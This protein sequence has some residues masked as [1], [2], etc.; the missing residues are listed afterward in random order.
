MTKTYEDIKAL[1]DCELDNISKKPEL[2]DQ[3]LHNLD[4]IIDIEKDMEEIE[5]MQTGGYS[6]ARGSY[7]MMPYNGTIYY[8]DG[9]S[10]GRN[11]NSGRSNYGYNQGY[12]QGGNSGRGYSNNGSSYGRYDE[13]RMMPRDNWM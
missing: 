3:D 9:S 12:A 13:M 7:G 2:S 1:L 6:G 11:G 4:K 10:Y 5:A 8:E